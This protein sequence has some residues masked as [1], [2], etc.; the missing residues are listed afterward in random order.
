MNFTDTQAYSSFKF[1]FRLFG[2][3]PYLLILI[4]SCNFLLVKSSAKD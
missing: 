4:R 2:M 1:T 3:I